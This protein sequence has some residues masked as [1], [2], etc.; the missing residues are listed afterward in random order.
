MPTPGRM[1]TRCCSGADFTSDSGINQA[2]G[3][4]RWYE[5]LSNGY[6]GVRGLG[7]KQACGDKLNHMS[8]YCITEGLERPGGRFWQVIQ[9]MKA[10]QPSTLARSHIALLPA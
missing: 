1:L 9:F 4:L 8:V 3:F 5:A 10:L 6:R 2:S 7:P